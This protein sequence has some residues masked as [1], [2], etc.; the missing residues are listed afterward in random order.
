MSAEVYKM[1]DKLDSSNAATEQPK[2]LAIIDSEKDVVIDMSECKY[3]SSA[4]LRVLLYSYKVAA[5]K[6]VKVSLAGVSDEV[7]DVMEMT[8]FDKF[9]EF[10]ATAKDAMK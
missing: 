8:G 5:P 2:I 9:F 6:G 7:K 10:F 1:G 4:G 3:V